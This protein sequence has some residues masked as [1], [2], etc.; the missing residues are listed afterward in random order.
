MRA[1]LAALE[2]LRR[3][4][5][6]D[7]WADPEEQAI[8]ARWAGWGAVP[9]VFDDRADQFAAERSELRRLLGTEEA[10][11]QARRTTLN[12]HYTSA[13]VVGA[14]WGAA[15][16]LG[17][18]GRV[19]VLEPGC[20]SGNFLGFAPEGA[21][22]TGVELDATTATIAEHL[23]GARATIHTG[24]FEELRVEDGAFDLAPI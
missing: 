9:K 1:N 24:A 22:L 17:V 15:A 13:S 23:Y 18:D 5:D 4:R 16:A 3:C 7:R 19:R 10:W 14:M 12:A 20:G 21:V 8:L 11:A 6:E 2:V